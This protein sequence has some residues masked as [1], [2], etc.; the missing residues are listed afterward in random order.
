M[1]SLVVHEGGRNDQSYMID[2]RRIMVLSESRHL[3]W[4]YLS[5]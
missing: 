1:I 5:L 2:V 4:S 3:I